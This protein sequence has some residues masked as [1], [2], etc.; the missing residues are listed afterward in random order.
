MATQRMNADIGRI[1]IED[2][3]TLVDVHEDSANLVL[4]KLNGIKFKG[5]K[6]LISVAR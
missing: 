1:D 2:S 3:H 5:K 4:K 6:L